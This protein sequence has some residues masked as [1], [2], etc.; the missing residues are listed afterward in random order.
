M[1]NWLSRWLKPDE[2]AEQLMLRYAKTGKPEWL[3]AL[4]KL[5]GDDL[6]HFLL[7][8]TDPAMAADLCQSAWVKVIEKREYY[9]PSGKFKSWLFTLGRNLMIDQLRHQNRWQA[10]ALEE[11][12]LESI[13]LDD[14]MAAKDAQ[15]QFD[16]LLDNLPF[17]QKEAFVLQQ[18]GFSLV[19][20]ATITGENSETIKSRLRYARTT[21]KSFIS[22]HFINQH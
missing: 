6:Y 2:S 5:N 7:S 21:F 3:D 8:Q 12:V 4:V 16:A 1:T 18:D 19:E 11:D 20:I 17:L 22:Q 9:Q 14:E 15:S 13:D 10:I